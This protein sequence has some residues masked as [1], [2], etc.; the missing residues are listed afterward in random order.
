MNRLEYWNN[1]TSTFPLDN[2]AKDL[3]ESWD[4]ETQSYTK[5]DAIPE[6]ALKLI[7]GADRV[8]DFGVGL[9]RNYGYLNELF[10]RVHGYDLRGM[11]VKAIDL[12]YAE[13]FSLSCNWDEIKTF[14][15]DLV[16]SSV[17]FQHL[18]IAELSSKLVDIADIT[19]YLY[20]NTRSYNDDGRDFKNQ[21]GGENVLDF[22]MKTNLFEVLYCSIPTEE[23]RLLKDETHFTVLFKTK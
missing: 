21:T 7:P 2:L 23:A 1:I 11:I 16:Y 9:G 4:I 5:H 17:C 20:I 13:E 15:Y 8:L 22:I 14:K 19:E 12:G 10:Y 18:D 3:H 6:E